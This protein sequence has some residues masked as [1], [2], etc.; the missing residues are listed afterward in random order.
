M[1]YQGGGMTSGS[2]DDSMTDR[3]KIEVKT[4]ATVFSVDNT[5]AP[6]AR[7]PSQVIEGYAALNYLVGTGEFRIDSKRIEVMGW[8][9]LLVEDCRLVWYSE[10]WC[11][12]FSWIIDSHSSSERWSSNQ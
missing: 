4:G 9:N 12:Y 5:L 7:T 8:D 6:T 11:V 10:Q 3:K 1:N 2:V